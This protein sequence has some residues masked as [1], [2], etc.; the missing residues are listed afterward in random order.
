MLGGTLLVIAKGVE[1]P[2]PLPR[3]SRAFEDVGTCHPELL[4]WQSTSFHQNSRFSNQSL[5]MI[6]TQLKDRLVRHVLSKVRM[7]NT[8][9]ANAISLLNDMT[10]LQANSACVFRMRTR[11]A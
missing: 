10:R 11:S 1:K 3:Q 2:T 6:N 5:A 9:A 8:S 4:S 7:P